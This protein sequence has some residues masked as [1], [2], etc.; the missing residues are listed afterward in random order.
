MG[1][2]PV[3]HCATDAVVGT[4]PDVATVVRAL[5]ERGPTAI[6][7][8]CRDPRT[9][10]WS[11]ERIEAAIVAAWSRNLIFVDCRDNLVAL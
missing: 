5:K 8:L 9:R 3:T 4:P 11:R 1:P 6:P 7:D 2:L 10:D